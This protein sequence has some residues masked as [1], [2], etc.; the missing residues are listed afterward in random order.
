MPLLMVRTMTGHGPLLNR[1]SASIWPSGHCASCGNQRAALAGK[2][3]KYFKNS[4]ILKDVKGTTTSPTSQHKSW[5]KAQATLRQ[6]RHDRGMKRADIWLAP[7]LHEAVS[8]VATDQYE[9][10]FNAAVNGLL[11]IAGNQLGLLSPIGVVN[12]PLHETTSTKPSREQIKLSDCTIDDLKK[13]AQRYQA[14]AARL[15]RGMCELNPA[16]PP[17]T[18]RR[19]PDAT[20]R[21]KKMVVDSA[22]VKTVKNT[23]IQTNRDLLTQNVEFWQTRVDEY[24]AKLANLKKNPSARRRGAPRPI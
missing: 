22:E 10:V 4:N 8:T 15:Y 24:E 11:R 17:P 14:K 2:F 1:N 13:L 6:N 20:P 9:G 21:T 3:I 12:T 5:V 16:L 7:D 18:G 19:G 23:V